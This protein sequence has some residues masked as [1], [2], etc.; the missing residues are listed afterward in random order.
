M[1]IA[2]SQ[3]E[4][5]IRGTAYDCLERGWYRLFEGDTIMPI[6]NLGTCT[7]N[8]PD[9]LVISGGDPSEIREQTERECFE[10][11]LSENIPMLGVCHGA[12]FLNRMY[13]GVN[14][15]VNGHQGTEHDVILEGNTY[16]VNSY[17]GV[18]IK[19][20]GNNLTPIAW[21][22]KHIEAFKHNELPIWGLVW[23]PERMGE[24]VLP[25]ELKALING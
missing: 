23:H 4:L 19:E 20:L 7:L 25:K 22:D 5:T 11:A 16:T 6:P 10:Y 15:G 21:A 18:A 13:C 17:H 14:G 8:K 9:M 3:R 12:F 1:N 24:P 2:I